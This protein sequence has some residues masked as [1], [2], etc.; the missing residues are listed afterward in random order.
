MPFFGCQLPLVRGVSFAGVATMIAISADGGVQA[1]LGAVM[2]A[3]LIGLLITPAFSRVLRFF[4]PLGLRRP[5]ADAVER[6]E[7]CHRCVPGLVHL[8]RCFLQTVDISG[9]PKRTY[10][11]PR[12]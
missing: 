2:A 4:P 12:P 9:Q 6:R 1:I 7:R 10:R 11:D 5:P 3:S 8:R